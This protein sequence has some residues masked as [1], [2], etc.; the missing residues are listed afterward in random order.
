LTNPAAGTKSIGLLAF[1]PQGGT[2]GAYAEASATAC[3]QSRLTPTLRSGQ[4]PTETP[5]TTG[6][7]YLSQFVTDGET[8]RHQWPKNNALNSIN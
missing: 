6:P 2:S 5:H 1:V 8:L 3:E 7:L 4:A